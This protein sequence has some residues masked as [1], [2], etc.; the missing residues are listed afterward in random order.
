MVGL[1][2]EEEEVRDTVS[3][4][5][6]A[7][8]DLN[9]EELDSHFSRSEDLLAYG[10][11]WDSRHKKFGQIAEEHK[12]EL[13]AL[14]S[15]RIASMELEVHV[16]GSVAWVADRSHQLAETKDGQKIEG[17]LRTTLVLQKP[18]PNDPWLIIQFHASRGT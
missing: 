9:A 7:L 8:E 10:Q 3:S 14:K 4:I 1:S 16:R 13:Q 18:K 12:R 5:Y 11:R 17:D 15:L 2:K 6:K